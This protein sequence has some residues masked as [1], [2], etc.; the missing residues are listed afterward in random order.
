MRRGQQPGW[1]HTPA[2]VG[3]LQRKEEQLRHRGRG[4]GLDALVVV[5]HER[6]Q[7][8]RAD[9]AARRPLR[10]RAGAGAPP[11]AIT[12]ASGVRLPPPPRP[13]PWPWAPER[14]RGTCVIEG[15]NVANNQG[16]RCLDKWHF[17]QPE[18][19]NEPYVT[20]SKLQKFLWYYD[21][22]DKWVRTRWM[23]IR[24]STW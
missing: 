16:W 24:Q 9:D 8:R 21:F 20:E 7:Q 18:N 19:E 13:T 17:V 10:G 11:N 23:V 3:A 14:T 22:P 1:G 15:Q 6:L 2:I 12:A 5:P 4:E